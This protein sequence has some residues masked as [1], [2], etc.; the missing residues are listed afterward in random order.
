MSEQDRANQE[1]RGRRGVK[2]VPALAAFTLV[3]F[4][5]YASQSSPPPAKEPTPP[6]QDDKALPQT[7]KAV[8]AA[9]AFLESLD[10]TQ[11]GKALLEFDSKKKSGWSNLP[12]N[13]VPRNGVRMGDLTKA[14]RDAAL[15]VVAA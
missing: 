6:V 1:P 4:T 11:R 15:E 13:N 3:G 9:K 7:S 10:A 14:Q 12:V 5:L 2:L 8:A